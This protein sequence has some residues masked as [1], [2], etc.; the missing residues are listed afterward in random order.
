MPNDRFLGDDAD[1]FAIVHD[2]QL[3]E[4]S[5]AQPIVRRCQNVRRAHCNRCTLTVR[6]ANQ[7]TQITVLLALD[8]ALIFHPEVVIQFRQVLIARIGGERHDTLRL[9][10]FAAIL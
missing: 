3:R 1:Q 5:V 9:G 10:L 7:V 2:R 4:P 6:T 8:E